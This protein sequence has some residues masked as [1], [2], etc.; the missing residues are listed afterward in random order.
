MTM[1][2]PGLAF[3]GGAK[4]GRNVVLAFDI[5]FRSEIQ[6]ASVGLRFASE[7]VLQVLMRLG[8]FELH[9]YLL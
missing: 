4:Y 6:V 2:V 3:S 8:A 5:G 1:G 9:N 7:R